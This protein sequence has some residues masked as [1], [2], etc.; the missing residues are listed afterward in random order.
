MPSRTANDH[1]KTPD[2]SGGKLL[3]EIARLIQTVKLYEDNSKM[4]IDAAN[5]FKQAVKESSKGN[6]YTSLH[7]FNG[8]FFLQEEKLPLLKKNAQTFN[9]M[10]PFFEKRSIY[11][12]HFDADLKN[13]TTK[14]ILG[15][16]RLLN[17]ADQHHN[18]SE[19]LKVQLEKRGINWLVVIQKPPLVLGDVYQESEIELSEALEQEKG[20]AKK[21][22]HYAL[23][24]I[25]EVAQK[26]L[27]GKNASIRKS[28]RSVQKMVDIIAE[29][30]AAFLSLST[31]RIYDDYTFVHSLNVA[32]LAM[33]MGQRI[34]MKRSLLEELGLCGLFHDLGKIEI[35]IQILNKKENLT[36][37]E[38]KE[39]QK[40]PIKSA[41]LILKLKTGKYRKFHL[42]VSP[43]EHHMQ[44]D[45][46]G[47]P[48]VDKRHP[49]SLF[50]RILT[51]VD[52]YDAITSPRIYRMTSM[53][54]DKA[55]SFM[56]SSSGK[57]F[58]PVLLKVFVNMLGVYPIGTFL[59]LDT[60]EMGL[61]L[62]SPHKTDQ[63]RPEVQILNPGVN[64]QYRKG[65]IIDLAERN[66]G[67]GEYTRNIT[68]T[69][70]PSTL[71]IQPASYIL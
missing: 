49:I 12:F 27:S 35:P 41:M 2:L 43:L 38:F 28:V 40:H 22:Y 47:Y 48:S 66:P 5:A 61:A 15:F 4:V 16:V 45:H 42:F 52:V 54:P 9:Q 25:K 1:P 60:G 51:I 8:R 70:H 36:D 65:G 56:L 18:P 23:N 11:G 30:P 46:S 62:H 63:T 71:G 3:K 44:Y 32:I 13:T 33:L 67:T 58:D 53:S 14:E 6:E 31:I 7:I 57:H 24:S 68:R 37:S 20:G 50:G 69:Q 55:I 39:I 29:N 17:L 26:L 59:K 10:L 34:G 21:T 64:K 19:W